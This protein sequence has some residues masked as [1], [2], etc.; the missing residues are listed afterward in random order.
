MTL[1]E[2]DAKYPNREV[3]DAMMIEALKAVMD[4]GPKPES[5]IIQEMKDTIGFWTR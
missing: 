4:T 5:E 3:N 1:K 2:Y